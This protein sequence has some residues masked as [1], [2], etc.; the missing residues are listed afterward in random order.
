[1]HGESPQTSPPQPAATAVTPDLIVTEIV[2]Q[3][4]WGLMDLAE[5]WRYRELLGTLARRDLAVRYRQTILG[6]TW[7]ILQPLVMVTIM[8]LVFGRIGSLAGGSDVPYPL[9][10]LAGWLPWQMFARAMGD[11]SLSLTNNVN[12]VTKVYFPRLLLPAAPLITSLVDF[13]VAM[14]LLLII[15]AGWGRWPTWQIVAIPG[16]VVLALA[17]SLAVGLWLSALNAVYR[18][19]RQMIPFLTQVWLLLSP[20]AYSA[21]IVPERYQ[22][23][24]GL[25]PMAG[26]IGG[27]RWA[28]LGEPAP[29][30]MLIAS[31]ASV[32]VL[33]VGG[34][35][36]FRRM[37]ADLADVV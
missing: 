19:V 21:R 25:N 22:L 3:P 33:L 16:L 32:V 2:P 10:A 4:A 11:A 24:Y 5:I 1:M 31:V 15:M 26:V 37:E 7:V 13:A 34:L 18:D 35:W 23:L 29:G 14:A 28:L 6:V 9:L 36:Y 17:A 12:L 20:V 8:S 27:F 30:R